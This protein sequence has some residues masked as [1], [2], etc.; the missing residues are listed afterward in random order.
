M[1]R[2]VVDSDSIA[3]VGY[4]RARR[5]LQVEFRRTMEVFEYLDVPISE[6]NALLAAPS[7]GQYFNSQIRDRGYACQKVDSRNET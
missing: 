3:S 6:Y 4:D 7:K 5:T 2:I 1:L